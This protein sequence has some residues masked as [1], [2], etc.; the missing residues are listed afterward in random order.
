MKRIYFEMVVAILILAW[1]VSNMILTGTIFVSCFP[2]IISFCIQFVGVL[3][4]GTTPE[5]A[6]ED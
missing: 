2:I 3:V 6:S 5:E 4:V 1:T